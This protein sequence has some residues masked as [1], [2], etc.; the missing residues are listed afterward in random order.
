MAIFNAGALLPLP[1]VCR[2]AKI[3]LRIVMLAGVVTFA[4]I[5]MAAD[6]WPPVNVGFTF[7]ATVLKSMNMPP[8]PS[9]TIP[10]ALSLEVDAS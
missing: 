7:M 10:F 8:P 6:L 9:A 3:L 2:L 5:S 1:M 4:V